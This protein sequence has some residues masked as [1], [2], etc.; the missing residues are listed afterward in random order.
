MSILART[1]PPRYLSNSHESKTESI[2]K[3]LADAYDK[4]GLPINAAVKDESLVDLYRAR[5]GH[6]PF[7][8]EALLESIRTIAQ[9]KD[10]SDILQD[11]LKSFSISACETGLVT[12]GAGLLTD[13]S[14]LILLYKSS[15][16]QSPSHQ[17]RAQ[18][19][20]K[21]IADHRGNEQLK[22]FVSTGFKGELQQFNTHSNE[23][24]K[25]SADEK[26]DIILNEIRYVKV[27]CEAAKKSSLT[28][29]KSFEGHQESTTEENGADY[30]CP[31]SGVQLGTIDKPTPAYGFVRPLP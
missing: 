7:Q 16:A 25:T 6:D 31:A 2:Q 12:L 15:A 22:S 10:R 4:L 27:V 11:F 3:A 24:T 1:T 5:A 17:D 20:L 19:A 13:D 23:S 26:Y 18:K 28:P 29:S 21:L 9:H 14:S 30:T 8:K